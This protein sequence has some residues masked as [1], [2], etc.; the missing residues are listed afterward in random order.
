M[1]AEGVLPSRDPRDMVSPGFSISP[2]FVWVYLDKGTA[3]TIEL[4]TLIADRIRTFPWGFGVK[5]PQP[6]PTLA[7]AG[8]YKPK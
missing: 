8:D 1:T 6:I 5:G 3:R 2:F 7:G 4:G